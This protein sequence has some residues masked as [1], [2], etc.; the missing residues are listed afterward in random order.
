MM[1]REQRLKER[2]V[3]RIL[4]EEELKRLEENSKKAETNEAR[5]S[6]RHLKAEMERRQKELEQMAQEEENWIFDC[7]VCGV[8]GENLVSNMLFDMHPLPDFTRMMGPTALHVSNVMFGSTAHATVSPKRKQSEMIFISYALTASARLKKPH[9]RNCRR[10]SSRLEL[11]LL[12]NL[13]VL[14]HQPL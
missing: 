12:L 11:P 7:A 14:L 8:H 2:E 10:S 4:H 6:E 3:K 5:M 1:T 9:D 13:K